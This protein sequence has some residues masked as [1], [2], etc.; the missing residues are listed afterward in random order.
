[1][2]LILMIMVLPDRFSSERVLGWDVCVSEG[3]ESFC[4]KVVGECFCAFCA[5]FF[6]MWM[7]CTVSAKEVGF[8]HSS[9]IHKFRKPYDNDEPQIMPP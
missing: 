9:V 1:M 3:S 5:F 7:Y 6:R 2:I 4:W 8:I